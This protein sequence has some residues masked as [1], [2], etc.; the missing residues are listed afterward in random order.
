MDDSY[1]I[2]SDK[3]YLQVVQLLIEHKCEEL[4]IVI[5]RRKTRIVRLS[6]GFTF[7]KKKFSFAENGRIVVRPSRESVTRGRR[8][9]KK[10]RKMVEA[11]LMTPEH[12]ER[13]YQSWRGG[14]KRL[15]AHRTVL[16]MDALYR[17]LFSTSENAQRGGCH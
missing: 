13:S 7:L 11:G 2:H 4:G 10:Q 17:E 14:M 15:D 16:S 1:C 6:R 9:L 3:A 8:K 12:V 5:N